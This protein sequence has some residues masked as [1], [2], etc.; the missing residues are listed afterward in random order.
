MA[1]AIN[2]PTR[3]SHASAGPALNAF[4]AVSAAS[5]PIVKVPATRVMRAFC[6]Q[7]VGTR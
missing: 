1:A 7:R 2:A 4:I 3:A 5:N 6:S